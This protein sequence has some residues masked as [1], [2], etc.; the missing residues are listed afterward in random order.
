MKFFT[1]IHYVFFAL[2]GALSAGTA[3]AQG[4]PFK[5]IQFVVAFPPGGGTDFA[6]RLVANAMT[7]R[8]GQPIVVVNRVGAGGAIA[9]AAVAKAT[10]DGYTVLVCANPSI[11]MAPHLMVQSYDPIKDLIPL[12]KLLNVSTVLVTAGN[13]RFS[14]LKEVLD[15]ARA[16]PWKVSYGTYGNGTTMHIELEQLKEKAGLN[17][18]HVPYKGSGPVIADAMAG[19][20]TLGA[21]GTPPTMG[22]I[23]G[24]KLKALAIWSNTRL[25]VLP[26]VPT[27]KE[28]TGLDLVSFPT[29][30]GMFLPSGTPSEIVKRLEAEVILALRDPEVA[31]KLVDSGADIVAETSAQFA[32]TLQAE[33]EMFAASFKK[34]NVKAE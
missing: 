22:G 8:M 12:V 29:W 2:L 23:R 24:G 28:I 3:H 6:A 15:S 7:P 19:Q 33:S 10:P 30:Y 32:A 21:S 18:T 16:N 5:P 13:S 1:T 9:T 27:I 14:T 34:Y 25:S 11:T 26:D 20:I 17:I 31:K 4:F